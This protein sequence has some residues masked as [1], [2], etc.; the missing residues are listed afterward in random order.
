MTTIQIEL[1]NATAQAAC[2]RSLA[3][4]ALMRESG[5]MIGIAGRGSPNEEG[6]NP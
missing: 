1:P 6:I 5:S 3:R 4:W 2:G